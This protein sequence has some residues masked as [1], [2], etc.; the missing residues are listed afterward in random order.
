[1]HQVQHGGI[2]LASC[3]AHGMLAPD[4]SGCRGAPGGRLRNSA[5]GPGPAWRQ[6]MVTVGGLTSR[7]TLGLR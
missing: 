3:L 1:M 6:S 4:S 2:Y 7:R 5:A